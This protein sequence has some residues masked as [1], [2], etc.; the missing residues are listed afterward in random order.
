MFRLAP[1][2]V[3]LKDNQQLTAYGLLSTELADDSLSYVHWLRWQLAVITI[4]TIFDG[5]STSSIMEILMKN[6]LKSYWIHRK[7]L[8]PSPKTTQKSHPRTEELVDFFYSLSLTR[9]LPDD[10]FEVRK[11]MDFSR[12]LG[13]E[14]SFLTDGKWVDV[15][16]NCKSLEFVETWGNLEIVCFYLGNL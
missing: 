14:D 7:L 5:A 15:V 13:L 9:T 6:H 16:L 11:A 12:S 2:S 3:Q 1:R 4:T 8:L 10:L